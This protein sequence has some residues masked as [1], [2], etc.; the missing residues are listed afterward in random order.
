LVAVPIRAASARAP[1]FVA[2]QEPLQQR[3]VDFLH[4][5]ERGHHRGARCGRPGQQRAQSLERRACAEVVHADGDG[6]GGHEPGDGDDRVDAPAAETGD[7]F[8]E[9]AAARLGAE[10]DRD[11]GVPDVHADDGVPVRAQL[12]GRRLADAGGGAG[13]HVGP[14][15]RLFSFEASDGWPWRA[16]VTP[17][18][19]RVASPDGTERWSRTSR[20]RSARW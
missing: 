5:G 18:A 7:L 16:P 1:G 15:H 10:V 4:R 9:L 14:A 2:G 20:L 3:V 13:D 19:A 12:P 11:V 6:A 17:S 8:D